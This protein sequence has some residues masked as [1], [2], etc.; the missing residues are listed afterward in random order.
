MA[1]LHIAYERLVNA[2]H[3]EATIDTYRGSGRRLGRLLYEGRW[4]DP[5]AVMLRESL[6]RWVASV[7]TGEVVLELRRGDDYSILDTTRPAPDLPPRA[8]EHGAQ[9]GRRLRPARPHRPAD[10]A[11]PRHRGLAREARAVRGAPPADAPKPTR[12]AC[13]RPANPILERSPHASRPR[14]DRPPGRAAPRRRDCLDQLAG[15]TPGDGAWHRRQLSRPH[16]LAGDG[17][18]AWPACAVDV[19]VAVDGVPE[20][21]SSGTAARSRPSTR[22]SPATCW[23]PRPAT[24]PSGA[25]PRGAVIEERGAA[26]GRRWRVARPRQS[27]ATRRARLSRG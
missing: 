7:V 27:S 11:R 25:E 15:L 18:A 17:H 4:F 9:R 16:A 20:D 12:S 2:I 13:C 8:P 10:D 3:N 24:R 23:S 22:S 14:P 19:R 26:R 21:H 5:Q 1:L 6:Q